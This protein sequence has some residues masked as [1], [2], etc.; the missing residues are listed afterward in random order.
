MYIPVEANRIDGRK[1][2]YAELETV[3]QVTADF[4]GNTA[5]IEW[6][7]EH[8]EESS[9]ILHMCIADAALIFSEVEW[10]E[11]FDTAVDMFVMRIF[12]EMDD[13]PSA[14]EEVFES[15]NIRKIVRRLQE[16]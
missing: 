10:E 5:N 2:S 16:E 9:A 8:V 6:M 13:N 4:Y 3:Q 1:Y 15:E 14:A 12:K 7:K 11:G